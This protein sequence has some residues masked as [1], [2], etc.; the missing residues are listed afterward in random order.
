M[1]KI[2][3]LKD[4]YLENRFIYNKLEAILFEEM[5]RLLQAY[6]KVLL[7]DVYVNDI[8]DTV[9]ASSVSCFA[10]D[11]KLF[12]TINNQTDANL[13]QNDLDNLSTWSTSSG[14]NFNEL[15]INCQTVT[16]K[17]SPLI[18]EYAVNGKPI[19]RLNEECDLGVRV[20]NNLS[21]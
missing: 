13:L 6:L 2:S 5:R 9:I 1:S 12:K 18:H 15:K 8:H 20:T 4:I 16:R 11:T 14:L 10:D 3:I 19:G 7:L 17:R 21:W